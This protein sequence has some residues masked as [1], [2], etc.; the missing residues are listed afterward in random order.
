MD[1]PIRIPLALPVDGE[2]YAIT[3][4]DPSKVYIVTVDPCRVDMRSIIHLCDGMEQEGRYKDLR[5]TFLPI[6]F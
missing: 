3:E 6:Q 1:E 4:F 5:V 2:P